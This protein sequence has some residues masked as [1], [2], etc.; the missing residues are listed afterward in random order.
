[1]TQHV[2]SKYGLSAND[3]TQISRQYVIK[4][5]FFVIET[6]DSS[7]I[8]VPGLFCVKKLDPCQGGYAA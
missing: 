4:A 7:K 6:T 2:A 1:V 8:I 3:I 5:N